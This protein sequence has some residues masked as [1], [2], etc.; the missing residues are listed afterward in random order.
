MTMP[1]QQQNNKYPGSNAPYIAGLSTGFSLDTL[2][3][4][5]LGPTY[6]RLAEWADNT[7]TRDNPVTDFLFEIVPVENPTEKGT[8]GKKST[9]KKSTNKKST[10]RQDAAHN[11][12]TEKK[13][14]QK[15]QKTK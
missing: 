3:T 10:Q 8:S 4:A 11:K 12:S 1:S 2:A 13:P 5:P 6:D 15:K 9:Q 14:T 7:S